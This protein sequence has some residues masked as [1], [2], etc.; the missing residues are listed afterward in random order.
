MAKAA[1][2][3]ASVVSGIVGVAYL[4]IVMAK[5]KR[6]GIV[7]LAEE[8]VDDEIK[9]DIKVLTVI[10]ES[11]TD[12]TMGE[13]EYL[14]LTNEMGEVSDEELV[15]AFREAINEGDSTFANSKE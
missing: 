13:G 1:I 2:L 7:N 6:A 5:D 11:A 15:A 14:I 12:T 4:K 10:S 3:C 9:D 8:T